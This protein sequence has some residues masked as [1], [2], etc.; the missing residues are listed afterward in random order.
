MNKIVKLFA[1]IIL[2]AAIGSQSA[3]KKSYDQPPGATDELNIVA[4]TTI[5]SL[6]GLHTVPRAY[7]VIADNI[8]ISGI[9]TAN[10]KSGN[11]YKQLFILRGNGGS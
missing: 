7:D 10:D 8:I 4:N 5:E 11:F 6:K 3:C 1:A 2:F 9:V